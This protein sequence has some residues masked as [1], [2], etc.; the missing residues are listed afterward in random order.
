MQYQ[1]QSQSQLQTDQCIWL[2]HFF[3]QTPTST[4]CHDLVYIVR[5]SGVPLAGTLLAWTLLFQKLSPH[6][7]DE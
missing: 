6:P 7:P 5:P 4:S 2:F 1:Y 3:E